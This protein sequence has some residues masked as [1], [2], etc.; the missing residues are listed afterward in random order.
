MTNQKSLHIAIPS[1]LSHHTMNLGRSCSPLPVF[2]VFPSSPREV[3]THSWLS[4]A[5]NWGEAEPSVCNK[6][7]GTQHLSSKKNQYIASGDQCTQ[8]PL[9][10]E[11]EMAYLRRVICLKKMNYWIHPHIVLLSTASNLKQCLLYSNTFKNKV[12]CIFLL[13]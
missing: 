9:G 12:I 4:W 11:R 5:P 8:S 3:L 1:Q 13:L 10:T 7:K 2:M 6:V